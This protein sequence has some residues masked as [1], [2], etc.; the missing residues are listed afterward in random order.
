MRMRSC[1]LAVALIVVAG[2]CGDGDGSDRRASTG[3]VN[4]NLASI[5]EA[6]TVVPDDGA[7]TQTMAWGDL[8]RA[9]EIAGLERPDP[10]DSDAVADYLLTV[11]N[12]RS[13]GGVG[14]GGGSPVFFMPPDAAHIERSAELDGFVEDVGWSVLQVDRFVERQS[15]PNTIT[16]L[17]GDFDDAAITDA[18]GEPSGGG[19]VAG[20]PDQEGFDFQNSTPARPMGEPLWLT[21]DDGRLAVTRDAASSR[22]T[23]AALSGDD[24]P[25]VLGDDETLTALAEALDGQ[26]PY[27]ALLSRPGIPAMPFD[28]SD[29]SPGRAEALC[30]QAL[31][32]P[33]AGVATGITDDD[34]PVILVALA[35]ASADDAAANAA[36][37]E[38]I[39]ATGQ[40]AA[41]RQAWSELVELDGVETTGDGRVVLARLRPLDPM[42]GGIWD[43]LLIRR[44]S[45][46]SYC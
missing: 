15:P 37:L 42:G 8:A 12:G 9:S 3:G 40:S 34:G 11:L 32:Q 39:V 5:A 46:V 45:V 35:H 1:A 23:R 19:W 22:T 13:E 2:A 26:T 14:S 38:D 33:T 28:V 43:D 27:S 18:L 41:T 36:A 7:A 31:P 44:D 17:E 16:V 10:A 29:P 21:L 24:G 6:L 20:D 25:S 4:G 30:D